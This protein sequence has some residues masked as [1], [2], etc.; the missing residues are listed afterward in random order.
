MKGSNGIFFSAMNDSNPSPYKPGKIAKG[1]SWAFLLVGI[2]IFQILKPNA[3]GDSTQ[4][5]SGFMHTV[6]VT[7]VGVA[8]AVV[9]AV[10]GVMIEKKRGR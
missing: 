7:L 5:G 1:T 3:L 10:I 6:A 2:I 8:C 9:G 4:S